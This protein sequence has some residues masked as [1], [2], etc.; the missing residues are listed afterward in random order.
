LDY[1]CCAIDRRKISLQKN[2]Q[3]WRR[4]AWYV[5]FVHFASKF[6]NFLAVATVITEPKNFVAEVCD[7][8]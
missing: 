5:C 1:F 7:L 6:A 8:M 2:R 4:G 3:M